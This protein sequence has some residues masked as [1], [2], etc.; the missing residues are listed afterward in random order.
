MSTHLAIFGDFH[1]GAPFCS[2]VQWVID[3]L[4]GHPVDVVIF[5]G[6][7]VD[8]RHGTAADIDAAADLF[9]HITTEMNLPVVMIWGN[10][11]AAQDLASQFPDIPGVY[12][13]RSTDAVDKLSVPGVPVDFYGINVAQRLDERDV[14]EL[15]PPAEEGT[16]VG[17]FHTSLTGEW[18][19]KPCLPATREAL[20]AKGYDAWALGHVHAPHDFDGPVPMAWPGT[21]RMLFWEV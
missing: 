13:P 16:A 5:T 12:R 3:K 14:V 11:D 8:M 18:S 15:F 1:L 7:L 17:I 4:E 6:D 20:Y 10:H 19:K 9:R 2:G 21:G